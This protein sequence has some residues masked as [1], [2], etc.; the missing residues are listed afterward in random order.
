MRYRSAI[1]MWLFWEFWCY[2]VLNL[3]KDQVVL[4]V[5][6]WVDGFS[7]KSRVF[8]VSHTANIRERG[9]F[10]MFISPLLNCWTISTFR[11]LELPLY[12]FSGSQQL[13]Y[14]S[15]SS[16]ISRRQGLQ[17]WLL[18]FYTGTIDQQN[19]WLPFQPN[20]YL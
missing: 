20:Q 2:N 19:V 10:S 18:P 7:C 13:I 14:N 3:L 5:L 6:W 1:C 8:A 15:V 4:T 11:L 12:I 16:S 17:F 9:T